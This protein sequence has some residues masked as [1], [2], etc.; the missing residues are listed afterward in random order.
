M[1]SLFPKGGRKSSCAKLI[2]CTL[3]L[4]HQ[5]ESTPPTSFAPSALRAQP[6]P[7]P[8]TDRQIDVWGSAHRYVPGQRLWSTQQEIWIGAQTLRRIIAGIWSKHQGFGP[9]TKTWD[10]SIASN[11]IPQFYIECFINFQV[12]F[13]VLRENFQIEK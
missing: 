8:T 2:S 4:P 9:E 5:F 11:P 13:I 6:P 10:T 12:H 3:A 7:P 1:D